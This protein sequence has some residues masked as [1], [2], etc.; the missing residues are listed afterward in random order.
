[1]RDAKEHPKGE[2]SWNAPPSGSI[3]KIVLKSIAVLQQERPNFTLKALTKSIGRGKI[4]SALQAPVG[5]PTVAV[6]F[7]NPEEV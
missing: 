2:R 5:V 6:D 4:Y 1:M 7:L 3:R